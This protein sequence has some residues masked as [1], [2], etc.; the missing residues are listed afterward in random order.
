MRRQ[1][2]SKIA[3]MPPIMARGCALKANICASVSEPSPGRQEQAVEKHSS[4]VTEARAQALTRNSYQQLIS[5]SLTD[6]LRCMVR[7][8]CQVGI[9][10]GK[11]TFTSIFRST[12]P[13]LNRHRFK[14]D[15]AALSS[16]ALP[17]LS[18]ID[19][20]ATVPLPVSTV[21]DTTPFPVM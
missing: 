11:L 14:A 13:G 21:S 12:V 5:K 2:I 7:P 8:I 1:E 17:V 6:Y 15:N 9:A 18:E 10:H 20:S 3:A 4:A 19:A 16:I